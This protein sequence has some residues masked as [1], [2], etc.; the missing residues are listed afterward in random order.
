MGCEIQVL[1]W[2]IN[3]E[4]Q[5]Q[6]PTSPKWHLEHPAVSHREYL[7]QWKRAQ[8]TQYCLVTLRYCNSYP[9]ILMCLFCAPWAFKLFSSVQC[10][11]YAKKKKNQ[12]RT[13]LFHFNS[14]SDTENGLFWENKGWAASLSDG[15]KT[16]WMARLKE[17]LTCSQWRTQC[18]SDGDTECTL[19]K[20]TDARLRSADMRTG[21]RTGR[22]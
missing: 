20:F 3:M 19:S 12:N 6:L 10:G 14:Y 4:F 8:V 18:V 17:W 21:M 11:I 9:D 2:L 15:L 5:A 16:G 13:G 1:H 7:K 22:I